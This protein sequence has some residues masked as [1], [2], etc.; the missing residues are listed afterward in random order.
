MTI[1]KNIVT[2]TADEYKDILDSFGGV[3]VAYKDLVAKICDEEI[4]RQRHRSYLG[5]RVEM[6]E[7]IVNDSE[8]LESASNLYSKIL[9]PYNWYD[10]CELY[11]KFSSIKKCQDSDSSK[12]TNVMSTEDRLA[13]VLE[14]V[15]DAVL[16]V[17]NVLVSKNKDTDSYIPF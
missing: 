11:D 15:E 4:L 9:C 12:K 10:D 17:Q 8:I 14:I 13:E 16:A 5:A 3:L 7:S 1:N 6:L 2:F